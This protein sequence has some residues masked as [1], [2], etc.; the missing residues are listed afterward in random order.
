MSSKLVKSRKGGAGVIGD[1]RAG[2]NRRCKLDERKTGNNEVDD[3]F[4]DKIDNEV[5][6]KGQKTSKSINL[7]KKS[8]KCQKT[9]GLDFLTPKA[10]LAFF[11]L[12]QT[13][14]KAPIFH[15][16]DPEY[17]IWVEMDVSGYTIGEIFSQLTLEGQWH[18]VAFFSC[19]MIP[20]KTRYK[21]HNGKLLAIVE[22]FKTWKHYLEGLQYEVLILTNHNKLRQF[23]EMRNLSSR[24]VC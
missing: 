13:F 19:K 4:N 5:G 3:E 18:W 14:V 12:R 2:Y 21:T 11:K 23:M 16:F 20:A 9:V 1:S 6:K 15:Y 10:R 17:H 24:Q 22:T 7:F 8:S